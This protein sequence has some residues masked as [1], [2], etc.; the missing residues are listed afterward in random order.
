LSTIVEDLLRHTEKVE[1]KPLGT[2]RIEGH[3]P[4]VALAL[5]EIL[6][7]E[8][9]V[10]EGREQ[11]PAMAHPSC[12]ILCPNGNDIASQ[13]SHLRSSTPDAAVLVF[14][15][16]VDLRQSLKALRAGARGFLHA[17]MG[18]EQIVQA[19]RRASEGKT[20][21]SEEMLEKLIAQEESTAEDLTVLTPRQREILGLVVEGLSN[22]QIAERLFLTESTVK[23]HLR[24]AY[25]LLKVRNRIQA[26]RLLRAS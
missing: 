13:V 10:Y 20:V 12:I 22:A 4:L 17:G 18:P 23:Q 25:K 15:M 2:V 21:I 9:D 5:N 11:P 16:R 8:A 1:P 6:K 7:G 26:A 19:V 14:E 3:Y 24:M